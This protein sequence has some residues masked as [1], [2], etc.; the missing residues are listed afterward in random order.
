MSL[1]FS[2][3]SAG[4]KHFLP[5]SFVPPQMVQSLLCLKEFSINYCL[6]NR[7]SKKRERERVCV[8]VC[9]CVLV[10]QSCLTLHDPT[11]CSPPGSPS[12]E[13]SRQEY[14]S[15]RVDCLHAFLAV[16]MKTL[17]LGKIEGKRR[18]GQQSKRWLDGI[19]NSMDISLSKLWEVVK[20]KEAWH[21]AVPGV[22]KSQTRLSN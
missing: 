10:T 6:N 8:C 21:A 13:F 18:R 1:H 5:F 11:G 16:V 22:A 3:D 14:W 17:M 15:G 2:L 4:Q 9:V 19:T 12:L 20:D 7:T